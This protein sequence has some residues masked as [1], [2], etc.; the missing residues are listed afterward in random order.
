MG[1]VSRKKT[2]NIKTVFKQHLSTPLSKKKTPIR[3]SKR[4]IVKQTI[5]FNESKYG[6]KTPNKYDN[7]SRNTVKLEDPASVITN[8]HLISVNNT[9][10]DDYDH[11]SSQPSAPEVLTSFIK[12]DSIIDITDTTDNDDE[13]KDSQST[14]CTDL[15]CY[16]ENDRITGITDISDDKNEF[17]KLQSVLSQVTIPKNTIDIIDTTNISTQKNVYNNLQ[18]AS[19]SYDNVQFINLFSNKKPIEV[20]TL[21]DSSDEEST[22][23]TPSLRKP[24][25]FKSIKDRLGISAQS[26]NIRKNKRYNSPLHHR[27]TAKMVENLSRQ[28]LFQDRL[29]PFIIDKQRITDYH[30][31]IKNVESKAKPVQTSEARRRLR[32]IIID[33]LNIGHA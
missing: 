30:Q 3:R 28:D 18:T 24:D 9:T 25:Q 26:I 10:N 31:H 4:N 17:N 11:K 1:K 15:T 12:N 14:L 33:G 5:S 29:G 16:I 22:V 23:N 13:N 6:I 2:K 20:I 32:P 8:D 21:S 19:S 27:K 7:L